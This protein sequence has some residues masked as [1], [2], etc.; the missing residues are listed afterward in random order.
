MPL[1]FT[2]SLFGSVVTIC[3]ILL[4]PL[5]KKMW[6]IKWRRYYLICNIVTFLIPFPLFRVSYVMLLRRIF[7]VERVTPSYE[8]I[9]AD[10]IQITPVGIVMEQFG[11]YLFLIGV[12]VTSVAI[13]YRYIR[14]YKKMRYFF[15]HSE[16]IAGDSLCINEE[17]KKYFVEKKIR[18]FRCEYTQT[19]FSMGA[20]RPLI[21]LPDYA[22][23]GKEL[24]DVLTHEMTHIRH[25]DN[26]W[27]LLISIIIA[28]NFYNPLV[29]YLMRKWNHV[30]ELCCDEAV[31]AHKN[32]KE[33]QEYGML[34]LKMAEERKDSNFMP[35]AGMSMQSK[36]M[37]ERIIYMKT[38]RKPKRMMTMFGALV[39]GLVLLS[40]SCTILAYDEKQVFVM[41]E[42]ADMII[43]SYEE[44]LWDVLPDTV[45]FPEEYDWMII[46]ELGEITY[47]MQ[48]ELEI[49]QANICIHKYESCKLY[50]HQKQANGGCK[51]E[52]Y[53]GKQCKKC[54]KTVRGAHSAT[55]S[56]DKCKH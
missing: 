14:K 6:S 20:L 27:K 10:V 2:M 54:G 15:T 40:S 50:D 43:V 5:A 55:L 56:Y 24:E 9:T 47:V 1:L 36:E 44:Q 41:D 46:D 19:P 53:E 22:W 21:V 17:W 4:E 8:E 18:I 13:G 38:K 7:D 33:I 11:M 12:V 35:I 52:E 16:E 25:K 28:L 42:P 32:K 31:I 49:E 34:I 45:A 3:Y 48:E 51:M 30:I 29:Y 39:L 23:Q 37:E 26:F